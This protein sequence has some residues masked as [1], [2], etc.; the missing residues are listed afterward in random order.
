[1][2]LLVDAIIADRPQRLVVVR[3]GFMKPF[4][5]PTLPGWICGNQC[6][7][8]RMNVRSFSIVAI[9][10]AELHASR[11]GVPALKPAIQIRN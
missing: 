5:I 11:A 8:L 4:T 10:C 7:K 9:V 2:R 1:M 6:R 3:I